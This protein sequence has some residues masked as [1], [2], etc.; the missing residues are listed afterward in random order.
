MHTAT[1]HLVDERIQKQQQQQQQ[2]ACKLV[3]KYLSTAAQ[4]LNRTKS[5]HLPANTYHQHN[6]NSTSQST[7]QYDNQH[8]LTYNCDIV[9]SIPINMHTMKVSLDDHRLLTSLCP[10]QSIDENKSDGGIVNTLRRSLRKSKDRFSHKRSATMKSCQSLHTYDETTNNDQD[11]SMDMTN[12]PTLI[13]RQHHSSKPND[14]PC[15]SMSKNRMANFANNINDLLYCSYESTCCHCVHLSLNG[16]ISNS[17]CCMSQDKIDNCA[18][19]C[20]LFVVV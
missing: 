11:S 13:S 3:N 18:C 5:F 1:S 10:R 2:P 12:T 20:V 6:H 15:I 14:M 9:R 19:Q 17:T 16:Q 7:I 8:G 4:Y